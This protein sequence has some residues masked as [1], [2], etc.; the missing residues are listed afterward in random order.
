MTTIAQPSAKF[1]VHACS[2]SNIANFARSPFLT[3][4]P[5]TSY[6]TTWPRDIPHPLFIYKPVLSHGTD[7]YVIYTGS[8]IG[9]FG[10]WYG[11]LLV[12]TPMMLHLPPTVRLSEVR[13]YIQGFRSHY[14]VFPTYE[15]ALTAYTAAYNRD[16]GAP[17]LELVTID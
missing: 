1:H 8:R 3:T 9:I 11:T 13:P 5:V 7:F 15:G 10:D 14:A 12:Y 4:L 2:S 6:T 16:T 17:K